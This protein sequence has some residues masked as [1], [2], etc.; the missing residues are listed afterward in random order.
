MAT[1]ANCTSQPFWIIYKLLNLK[2]KF[3]FAMLAQSLH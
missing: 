2:D 3:I 1:H